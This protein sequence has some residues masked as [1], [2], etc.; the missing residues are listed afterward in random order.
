MSDRR[1]SWSRREFVSG[2]MLTATPGLVGVR[3]AQVAAEP[4]PETAK[5]TM[6][7]L[8]GICQSPQYVA[9]DL[10]RAEGFTEV[11]YPGEIENRNEAERRKSGVDVEDATWDKLKQLA[12]EYKLA[13]ELDLK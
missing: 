3:P 9:A 7:R 1:E 6:V 2:L 4:P 13:T 12:S 10:L 8:K 11:L 5:I